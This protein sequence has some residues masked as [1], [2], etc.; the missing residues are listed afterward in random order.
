[1]G[2]ET[3]IFFGL[4]WTVFTWYKVEAKGPYIEYGQFFEKQSNDEEF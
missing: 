2:P 1:M 4:T 3:G